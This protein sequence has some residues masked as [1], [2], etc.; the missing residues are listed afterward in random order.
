MKCFTESEM[1]KDLLKVYEGGDEEDPFL[2]ERIKQ[3]VT[4]Y[5]EAKEEVSLDQVKNFWKKLCQCIKDEI[6]RDN[7]VLFPRFCRFLWRTS[8]K[9]W[10][11]PTKMRYSKYLIKF[12]LQESVN[13]ICQKILENKG[14]LKINFDDCGFL[15][16]D[17]QIARFTFS[18][19]KEPEGLSVKSLSKPLFF[20]D[21]V[22]RERRIPGPKNSQAIKL[23]FK[24][25][26]ELLRQEAKE[27]EKRRKEISSRE[28]LRHQIEDNK[29]KRRKNLLKAQKKFHFLQFEERSQRKKNEVKQ[30]RAPGIFIEEKEFDFSRCNSQ[31]SFGHFRC[32]KIRR[33][34]TPFPIEKTPGLKAHKKL[35][36]TRK[37]FREHLSRQEEEKFKKIK[38]KKLRDLEIDLSSAEINKILEVE[39]KKSF[40]KKQSK[41]REE[42]FESWKIQTEIRS[43]QRSLSDIH[44]GVAKKD[45]LK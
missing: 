34:V 29:Q 30:I 27:I 45:I 8:Q 37:K 26:D 35:I 38:E 39:E 13:W 10:R 24:L 16:V 3:R 17:H 18:K 32:G 25:Q 28:E 36:E 14:P 12:F 31:P 6:E 43:L 22:V 2:R 41:L 19:E 11:K 7:V 42:L 44:N 40:K 1:F 15:F 5:K 23:A 4:L 20:K 9:Q 21:P 33:R